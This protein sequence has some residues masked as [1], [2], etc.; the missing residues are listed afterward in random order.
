[1]ALRCALQLGIPDI[2]SNQ[3]G[4]V[5]LSELVAQ[6]SIPPAKSCHLQC[7]M[8]LLVHLGYFAIK[9]NDQD[10]EGY[11]LTSSSK[12]LVS[13][14][15]ETTL[16]PYLLLMSDPVIVTPCLYMADWFRGSDASPFEAV[17]GVGVYEYLEKHPDFS[18]T[19]NQANASVSDVETR[20]LLKDL[21]PKLEG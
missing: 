19:I 16:A 12:L 8:Q 13:K 7:V 17:H 1:M 11:T 10:Q 14:N 18:T 2:V 20:G 6:L 21:I 4:P 3:E 15:C 9:K 5:T